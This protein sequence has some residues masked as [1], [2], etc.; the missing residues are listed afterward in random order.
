MADTIT[1]KEEL[2]SWFL[3]GKKPAQEQFAA[4][5]DSYWHKTEGMSIANVDNLQAVLNSKA[6]L[7]QVTADLDSK[8]DKVDGM[9]LSTNDYTNQEKASLK[10][11]CIDFI[12]YNRGGNGG[13]EFF[14]NG[15]S[16]FIDLSVNTETGFDPTTKKGLI[17]F[18]LEAVMD[19]DDS[20]ATVAFGEEYVK[21]RWTDASNTVQTRYLYSNSGGT[22]APGVKVKLKDIW[23]N[24]CLAYF[25]PNWDGICILISSI[26]GSTVGSSS[27]VD[28]V[29]LNATSTSFVVDADTASMIKL[30]AKTSGCLVTLPTTLTADKSVTFLIPDSSKPITV[31]GTVYQPGDTV[32]C[33][34]DYDDGSKTGSWSVNDTIPPTVPDYTDVTAKYAL[35]GSDKAYKTN[36]SRGFKVYQPDTSVAKGDLVAVLSRV[37]YYGDV[38]YDASYGVEQGLYYVADKE[39]ANATSS[40]CWIKQIAKG[41]A[42]QIVNSTVYNAG[43]WDKTYPGA[44]NSLVTFE[45]LA[46]KADITA[47]QTEHVIDL[48]T[49][50]TRTG[51]KCYFDISSAEYDR[52]MTAGR[53]VA[54]MRDDFVVINEGTQD[55]TVKNG[56]EPVYVRVKRYVNGVLNDATT[57]TVP[58][59]LTTTIQAQ[60]KDVYGKAL[61]IAGSLKDSN[62][63]F[64]I[65]IQQE[66]VVSPTII[67]ANADVIESLT[68]NY[69]ATKD[70]ADNVSV[71]SCASGATFTLPLAST[72]TE[73]KNIKLYLSK[74]SL[75]SLTIV[76]LATTYE[77]KAGGYAELFYSADSTTWTVTVT[78]ATTATTSSNIL[79]SFLYFKT[80]SAE[81]EDGTGCYYKL[82]TIKSTGDIGKHSC[83]FKIFSGVETQNGRY[84]AS[85]YLN[86]RRDGVNNFYGGIK[87]Y[88]WFAE[89]NS[90]TPADIVVTYTGSTNEEVSTIIWKKCSNTSNID[91]WHMGVELIAEAATFTL[92][93]N[94]YYG[95]REYLTHKPATSDG[96][97]NVIDVN[98]TNTTATTSQLCVLQANPTPAIT[99]N[100]TQQHI[101]LISSY[102]KNW[103]TAYYIAPQAG[104]L[105]VSGFIEWTPVGGTTNPLNIL[106]VVNGVRKMTATGSQGSTGKVAHIMLCATVDNI[107]AGDLIYI[108]GSLAGNTATIS[109]NS[110]IKFKITNS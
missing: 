84:F 48:G 103:G 97:T 80:F 95:T 78:N 82:A 12:N 10:D 32:F 68:G 94:S 15:D 50:I 2:K 45:R 71:Q 16:V 108:D 30:N 24:V 90:F 7:I 61:Y 13:D 11:S 62:Y 25:T 67:P 42:L 41:T 60:L 69:A 1:L 63:I 34:F 23:G 36:T 6:N 37:N 59:S 75:N 58:L 96:Y 73:D 74:S 104:V 85:F 89:A 57:I 18:S 110:E 35:T 38:Q 91:S 56:Y 106:L 51:G 76:N 54:L 87:C 98:Y 19:E 101:A 53:V 47:L 66:T 4:W 64:A 107:K 40:Y 3:N 65:G 27:S 39:T 21:L 9:G 105:E 33:V 72:M 8:V 109:T 79:Q 88:E 5:M 52:A 81:D 100:T 70:T 49:S 83:S 22:N 93:T 99:I 46:D 86:L 28:T 17:C 20:T 31:D 29:Y 77:L 102:T 55:S 26:S 14:R 92:A 44:T 43:V